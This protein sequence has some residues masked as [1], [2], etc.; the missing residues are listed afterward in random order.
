M[1]FKKKRSTRK[2]ALR[3]RRPAYRRRFYLPIGGFPKS[4]MVRLRYVEYTSLNAGT[5]G[6]A[7][8][9]YV[10]NGMYDPRVSVGGHQPA[11]FDSWMAQYDHFCVLGSKLKVT[12][13]PVDGT[14]NVP[15]ILG[16]LLSDTGSRA[17]ASTS[18]E[19]LL[20]SRYARKSMRLA[21]P[22]MGDKQATCVHT[23]SASKFFGKSK[24]AV[25]GTDKYIG[26]ASADP[27]DGAFFEIFA[28][29]PTATTD[30]SGINLLVE[31]EYVAVLSEPK[32]PAES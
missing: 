29:A 14:T 18:V 7:S 13:M 25:L 20:E 10:A 23:F 9:A 15:S 8:V 21:G 32:P 26:S 6:I 31:I 1:P 11:N 2:R 30:P 5:G 4:K 22:I 28:G 19:Y 16:I 3:K 17:T 27:T 12:Y 24:Q